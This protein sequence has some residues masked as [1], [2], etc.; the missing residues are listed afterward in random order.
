MV[1]HFL[2]VLLLPLLL[3]AET[4]ELGLLESF[5]EVSSIAT[6][7]KLNVDDMPSTV[8]VLR[9]EQL[10][11]LGINN[12][13]EA[14][15]LLPGIEMD[16]T[17]VGWKTTVIRGIKNP[18][19]YVFDKIKLMIDGVDVGSALHGTI[20]YYLDFPVELIERIEV[21]KGPGSAL[22]GTGAYAGVINVVTK[23]SEEQAADAFFG[24]IGSYRFGMA[25]LTRHYR[26]N[27]TFLAL[28]GYY[29]RNEKHLGAQGFAPEPGRYEGKEQSD[30]SFKDY[31]VGLFARMRGVTLK[32]RA[33]ENR[34]GN[35]YGINE[36]LE[37][38]DNGEG[39]LRR[40]LF[41]EL[42]Y[43]HP[44]ASQSTLDLKAGWKHYKLDMTGSMQMDDAT[45]AFFYTP[46]PGVGASIG[47][48]LGIGGDDYVAHILY[49]KNSY[50]ADAVLNY[51]EFSDHDIVAGAS[52]ST[53]RIGQNRYYVEGVTQNNALI[54]DY[55][56]SELGTA[57][58]T[59]DDVLITGDPEREIRALYLNDLYTYSDTIA[60]QAGLRYDDYKEDF[61]QW[62]HKLGMIYRY[63]DHINTKLSYGRSFRA[64]S[65][66][67]LHLHDNLGG[68]NPDLKPETIDSFEANLIYNDRLSSSL[69]FNLYYS[70]LHD[71]ID[72]D[73]TD[74]AAAMY[75]NYD[76][77]RSK[78]FEL[79]YTNRFS[80]ED[81]LGLNYAYNKTD[82]D[83]VVGDD[84]SQDM[85]GISKAMF[86]AYYLRQINSAASLGVR[87]TY[88]GPQE[89]NLMIV[90]PDE[91]DS[92]KKMY[93]A[94]ATVDVTL[95]YTTARQWQFNLSIYNLFNRTVV[96]PSFNNS[97]PQSGQ[98][99]EGTH[100][101]AK[102]RIPY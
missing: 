37:E 22:Y 95:A 77:R 102:V 66:W 9:G 64:P 88:Y 94:N 92:Y 57:L 56:N 42:G 98:V 71:A 15:A 43:Q 90:P 44:V 1:R 61:A 68:G 55:L 91:R 2:P 84:A 31:S 78:G 67:E 18:E 89:A 69:V 100:L 87:Y 93:P 47:D 45:Y 53:L 32:A 70:I 7:T 17:P 20:E 86:K 73:R 28:D 33:K 80:G 58:T 54:I 85:P 51:R 76:R 38:G 14:L 5:E 34:S 39:N 24:G 4:D 65:L 82:Y 6:K 49:D 8:N 25:G 74:G 101:M 46:I 29:Q 79:E 41:A 99:R 96:D 72:I 12:L 52:Y 16:R 81:E 48:I 13:A 60:F 26:D 3:W 62:S 59:T 40:L 19:S 27:H 10:Q 63:S 97:H 30:E 83:S 11:R 23:A 50:H 36:S 21:L 35:Y 75:T